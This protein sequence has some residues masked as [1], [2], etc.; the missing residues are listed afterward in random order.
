MQI[1]SSL[2][3]EGK[4]EQPADPLTPLPAFQDNEQTNERTHSDLIYK[5]D[6]KKCTCPLD[7]TRMQRGLCEFQPPPTS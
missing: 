5:E 6:E 1:S 7:Y 2:S 3:S 4:N